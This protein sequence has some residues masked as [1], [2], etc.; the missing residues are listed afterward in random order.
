MLNNYLTIVKISP[1]I[2]TIKFKGETMSLV[3]NILK[4]ATITA[5]TLTMATAIAN[6]ETAEVKVDAKIAEVT[7][8]SQTAEVKTP[9]TKSIDVKDLGI[10]VIG[11][12][13]KVLSSATAEVTV[14][15][16]EVIAKIGAVEIKYKELAQK[17]NEVIPPFVPRNE[18]KK[19]DK[20]NILN[21]MLDEKLIDI[22]MKDAKYNE[23]P[24]TK[25]F[26][27]DISGKI[28]LQ[29]FLKEE[30][31][32]NIKV[33]DAEIKDFFEKNK[34]TQLKGMTLEQTKDDITKYL[35]TKKIEPYFN[36]LYNKL[37]KEYE[38]KTNEAA[39]AKVKDIYALDA[40][41]L[42]EAMFTTKKGDIK[43]A[44]ARRFLEIGKL[45]NPS[46]PP[47]NTKDEATAKLLID[48]IGKSHV[49]TL[50]AAEKGFTAEKDPKIKDDVNKFAD[51][52]LRKIFLNTNIKAK[53]DISE[54]EQQKYYDDHKKEFMQDEQVK[55][56]HILVKEETKAVELKKEIDGG[57][58]FE[59]LA[60]KN[61]T[62]PGS[63]A[64]GGDLGFFG[65]G[66]MVKEFEDAAF[67][68][69]IGTVTPVVKSQFGYHIIKVT[70]KQAAKQKEFKEVADS[71]KEKLKFEEKSKAYK[72]FMDDLKT[73][74]KVEILENKIK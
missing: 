69:K 11:A 7:T 34:D 26:I 31:D 60:K 57:A 20:I 70:D 25:E 37:S 68:A 43:L 71:I 58:N 74:N 67:G 8:A 22:A 73:K 41:A 52:Q 17:M 48:N 23:K 19:E 61:S 28:A 39:L 72:S 66:M 9:D 51:M 33:E 42:D 38:L 45:L 53:E 36:E 21:K 54:A 47:V 32:K 65:H 55:A 18:I 3:K 50:Y 30:V 16:E 14:D 1:I 44:D 27:S 24:E 4:T 29:H 13:G 6:A 59:D 35:K 49:I 63:A 62:D 40:K 5:A 12:D 64:N 15:S 56:S 10:N 2:S 46:M